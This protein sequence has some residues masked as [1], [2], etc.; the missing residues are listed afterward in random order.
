DNR[1]KPRGFGRACRLGDRASLDR[2]RCSNFPIDPPRLPTRL[3][4]QHAQVFHW[5]FYLSVCSCSCLGSN[6]LHHS[7]AALKNS[8]EQAPGLSNQIVDLSWVSPSALSAFRT[9][10]AFATNDRGD[11]LNDFVR[12]KLR[13]QLLWNNRNQRDV[14]I[15]R[16]RKNDRAIKLL[17]QRVG[18]R[19][20]QFSVGIR[21]AGH[22]DF[23]A[24][25][26]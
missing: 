20:Q 10:T 9:P 12:L 14:S 8:A 17:L 2:V 11:L 18:N 21:H 19:L 6:F 22:T 4:H 16:A 25:F 26:G 24:D 1:T 15:L 3:V 13:S 7:R 23:L 5:R